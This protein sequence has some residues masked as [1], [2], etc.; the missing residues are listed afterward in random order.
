M[1][2]NSIRTLKGREEL[3]TVPQL[4]TPRT[5]IAKDEE[6]DLRGSSRE[7]KE[8][9]EAEDDGVGD[10]VSTGSSVEEAPPFL[11]VD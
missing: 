3:G 10:T 11:L 8:G 2:F 6:I 9:E 5:H 4:P 1:G 7:E